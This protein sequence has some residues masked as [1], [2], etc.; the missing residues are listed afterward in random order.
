MEALAQYENILRFSRDK[1]KPSFGKAINPFT[2]GFKSNAM[3]NCPVF[4]LPCHK[5]VD[6]K[7]FLL[8]SARER[9]AVV[10]GFGICFYCFLRIASDKRL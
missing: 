10:E 9:F 7:G 3:E 6:C 5:L 1:A 2:P 8:K 4:N